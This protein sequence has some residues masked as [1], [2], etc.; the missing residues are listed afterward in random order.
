MEDVKWLQKSDK[1]KR[2][3]TNY[4]L[5]KTGRQNF[6]G[7]LATHN[8]I[9]SCI[10]KHFSKECEKKMYGAWRKHKSTHASKGKK[11]KSYTL[12]TEA[13]SNI[14]YLTKHYNLQP[15]ST[16]ELIIKND[17]NHKSKDISLEKRKK[18]HNPS[19][20]RTKT[21]KLNKEIANKQKRIIQLESYLNDL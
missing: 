4:L 14:K 7:G 8:E 3:A 19:E 5:K 1:F 18:K 20:R 17:F 12:S 9:I 15:S 10:E 16:I 21:D 6:S 11:Q 2:W 13:I